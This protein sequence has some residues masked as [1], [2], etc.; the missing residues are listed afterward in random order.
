VAFQVCKRFMNTG[1]QRRVRRENHHGGA[2]NPG[3]DV[4]YGGDS[5]KR[6]DT[7]VSL[8]A[9]RRK[10]LRVKAK[11]GHA[12]DVN[13]ALQL[14]PLSVVQPS[15]GDDFPGSV[16]SF[17]VQPFSLPKRIVPIEH[18][19]RLAPHVQFRFSHLTDHIESVH[20]CPTER[21]IAAC[22]RI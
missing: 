13:G 5:R 2:A 22:Q 11:Y 9:G 7:L 4:I 16:A 1:H 12:F 8:K 10:S 14:V 6:A 18:D 17:V 3:L 15:A 21:A 19:G 20:I